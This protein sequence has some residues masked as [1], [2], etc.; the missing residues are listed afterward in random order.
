MEVFEAIGQPT[1]RQILRV[2]AG[3][4]LSAGAVAARFE[5]TQPAISQHLR[6]L[7][8]A[9]LVEDRR[10]G[11]RRLYRVRPEGMGDLQA[12]LAEVLPA[13]LERLKRAAELE[14]RSSGASRTRRN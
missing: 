2:L 10:E 8:D 14:E 1:R 9:G 12:F 5:L 4:E 11:T 7:R 13:G 6:V 3:D